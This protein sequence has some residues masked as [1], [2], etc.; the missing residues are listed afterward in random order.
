MFENADFNE[1]AHPKADRVI[2]ELRLR[3]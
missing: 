1:V 2:M 3:D